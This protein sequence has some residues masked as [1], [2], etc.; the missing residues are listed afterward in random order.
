MRRIYVQLWY[1]EIT[2]APARS[3][4]YKILKVQRQEIG[5]RKPASSEMIFEAIKIGVQQ[6]FDKLAPNSATGKVRI[7]SRPHPNYKWDEWH[8]KIKVLV[9]RLQSGGWKQRVR[10]QQ[11]PKPT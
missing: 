5:T 10:T 3:L 7:N 11:K 2:R 6:T 8:S 1:G 4:Q 9:T